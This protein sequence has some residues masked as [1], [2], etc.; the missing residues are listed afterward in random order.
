MTTGTPSSHLS[1]HS[2]A[3][4]SREARAC[5]RGTLSLMP[6]Y[7]AW[8]PSSAMIRTPGRMTGLERRVEVEAG[9]QRVDEDRQRRREEQAE[10][11]AGRHEA[12]REVVRVALLAERG[13][14]QAA[15]G[16]DGDAAA[17]GE[18]A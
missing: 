17:A 1:S 11:A 5:E 18:R 4:I 9:D 3:P 12:E 15:D 13:V 7:A 10:R 8:T 6:T 16:D 2:A 14:E